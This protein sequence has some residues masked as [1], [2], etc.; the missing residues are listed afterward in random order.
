MTTVK[1]T[2]GRLPQ[3]V[4][5]WQQRQ[6][7]NGYKRKN[8]VTMYGSEFESTVD[9]NITPPATYDA[10]E[11]T[12]TVNNGWKIISDGRAAWLFSQEYP[13]IKQ[14]IKE[15]VDDLV[16]ETRQRVDEVLDFATVAEGKAAM[17]EL[18]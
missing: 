9:D 18:N 4:G 10:E 7:G 13:A 11:G 5:D 14:E 1:K 8:R 3:Y 2:I 6:A 17:D 15:E 12:I 16:E